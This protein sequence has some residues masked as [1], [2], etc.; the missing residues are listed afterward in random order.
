MTQYNRYLRGSSSTFIVNFEVH[1]YKTYLS[2]FLP[3]IEYFKIVESTLDLK[4]LLLF[5]NMIGLTETVTDVLYPIIG[6]AIEFVYKFEPIA[7]K[8]VV[9]GEYYKHL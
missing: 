2:F 5:I 7:A 6:S 4:D 3:F 8:T 1:S 9:L